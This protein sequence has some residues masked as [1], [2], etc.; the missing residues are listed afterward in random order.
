VFRILVPVSGS[1]VSRRGAEVAIALARTSLAPMQ[2]IY[3]AT[4][5][6]KTPRQSASMSMMHEEAILKDI[7]V[8]ASR[9]DVTVHTIMHANMSPDKAILQEIRNTRADLVVM[10]V[11]RV[12]GDT[13]NFG[14]VAA[15]VIEQS[16][17]SVLLVSS[18][19]SEP[20]RGASD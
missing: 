14:G 5:R 8:L 6:D 2:V 16:E 11:D 1:G 7:G 12:K 18:G 3:V 15:S 17:V 9:Y 13:L 20:R 4:T 19:D 10:G